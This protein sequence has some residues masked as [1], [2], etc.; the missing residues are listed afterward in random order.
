MDRNIMDRSARLLG[1]A[2][3]ATRILEIGAGYAPL[4]P[5]SRG[6]NTHVV[7]HATRAELREKY[8]GAAVDLDAIEEVDTV[9]RGGDLH[10]SV[11]AALHG[12]FDLLIAS[13]LIEHIPDLIGFFNAAGHLLRPDGVI[14]LAIPDR[15]FCFDF[16]KPPTLTG[17]ILEAHFRRRSRHGLRAAWSE[18][19]YAA[20]M[21][22]RLGWGR[23]CTGLPQ[24]ANPFEVAV[25][26]VH[27]FR[28]D[29]D[30]PYE[31]FHT[32]YFTPA[33]FSLVML[34]L[35]QVGVCDW[36]VDTLHGPENFEFFAHLRRGGERIGDP[37]ALQDRRMALL[38]QYLLE[39]R[40]QIDLALPR[41]PD[42]ETAAPAAPATPE[43][44]APP[45]ATRSSPGFLRSLLH[46]RRP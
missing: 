31:D 1:T 17:D 6:W 7:D 40:E 28:D 44:D 16:F 26:T 3:H 32:W 15:R 8:R 34:E 22:G 2:T 20:T 43:A 29:P 13:H 9:W 45:P 39:Q 18:R 30:A 41:D 23:D 42:P 21:D 38:R 37:A 46:R 27:G 25:R 35:A 36:R 5:R 33:G 19:A 24:F 4:A 14:A 11:P 12:S 10:Q